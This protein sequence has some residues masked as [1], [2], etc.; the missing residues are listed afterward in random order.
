MHTPQIVVAAAIIRAGEDG[1]QLLAAERAYPPQLAG[2]WEL[3]GGKAEPG[4]SEPEALVR[5]CLEE[6]GVLVTVGKRVGKDQP[7]DGGR[8]VLRA[9]S[10]RLERGEPVATEHRRLRWLGATELG[11]V[12]WLPADLPLLEPLRALLTVG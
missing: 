1:P 5:E 6:L 9:W 12:R 3:P 8:A 7:L 11:S 10:A 2:W 4:E